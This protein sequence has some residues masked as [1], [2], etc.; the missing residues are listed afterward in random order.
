MKK[1]DLQLNIVVTCNDFYLPHLATMLVSLSETNKTAIRI[2]LL[3]RNIQRK[4]INKLCNLV[5]D[6]NNVIVPIIINDDNLQ[7]LKINQHFSIVNYYRLL[8][9]DLLP[10]DIKKVLYFDSDLLVLKPLDEL[11]MIDIDHYY[12][13][14]VQ[15]IIDDSHRKKLGLS[16]NSKYFN[17][18][19]MLLNLE[20]WRIDNLSEKVIN[21][22]KNNPEK[23]ENV[24]QDG[25]NAILNGE[26]FELPLK[27]NVQ[28]YHF[29]TDEG[30]IRYADCISDPAIIHFTGNGTKPWQNQSEPHPYLVEYIYFRNKTPWKYHHTKNYLLV[31]IKKIIKNLLKNILLFLLKQKKIRAFYRSLCFLSEYI[32]TNSE[33]KLEEHLFLNNLTIQEQTQEITQN[34]MVMSGPFKNLLYPE[35]NSLGSRLLPKLIGS[36]EYELREIVENIINHDYDTL[37]DIGCAEGY[38]ACGFAK[39]KPNL[40]VFAYDTNLEARELCKKMATINNIDNK[41]KIE[42]NFTMNSLEKIPVKKNGFVFCDCEGAENFIFFNDGKNWSKLTSKFDLLIEIHDIFKPGISKYIYN[43][44][45]FTH[46]IKIIYS[47]ID[48]LRPNLVYCDPLE[49][50]PYEIKYQLMAEKRPGIMTWFYLTRK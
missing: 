16:I 27:W 13:A 35:L 1:I 17:S 34:K 25:L 31:K 4:K 44:F 11:W 32:N 43:L 2:F 46:N 5:K 3:H 14:A 21:Y 47:I 50:F 42:K 6:F 20:K 24:D 41:V 9:P 23:I 48:D 22:I 8:I 26:W 29:L 19:V 39:V 7:T 36:Y 37:I 40:D 10:V 18:G 33:P 15:N 28:S 45:S 38:Y 30:K 49:N 12:L